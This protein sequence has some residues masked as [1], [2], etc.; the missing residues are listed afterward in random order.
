MDVAQVEEYNV[1]T[2]S[3]LMMASR[4][5]WG[6]HGFPAGNGGQ[7]R[8]DFTSN[9]NPKSINIRPQLLV[10]LQE[11]YIYIYMKIL[12]DPLSHTAITCG[13]KHYNCNEM[14]VLQPSRQLN[15]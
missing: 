3:L 12:C 8:A 14:P 10:G 7:I 15:F 4:T 13:I 11:T 5:C 6:L 2:T 1:D 9:I